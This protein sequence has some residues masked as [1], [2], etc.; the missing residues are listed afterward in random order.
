MTEDYSIDPDELTED[1]LDAIAHER[2]VE[3][4]S[5]HARCREADALAN[6]GSH[7]EAGRLSIQAEQHKAAY[8][9]LQRALDRCQR[10][11]DNAFAGLT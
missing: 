8:G 7:D 2:D 10:I 9:A 3:L 5:A 6:A 11:K 1:L 4:A